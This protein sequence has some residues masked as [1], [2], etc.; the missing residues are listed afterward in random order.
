M[1]KALYVGCCPE[2]MSLRERFEL[3]ARAGFQGIELD[4]GENE[5]LK[6]DISPKE[7]RQVRAWADELGLG[8]T[9]LFCMDLWGRPITHNDPEIRKMTIERLKKTI[10]IASDM[11]VDTCL[12]VAGQVDEEHG[13]RAVWDR[14]IQV[15]RD[16]LLPC[17]ER[18][19]VTLAVETVWNRFLLSPIEFKHY[20]N[21]VNHPRLTCYF[22]AANVAPWSYPWDWIKELGS[23]IT[24][25]HVSGVRLYMTEFLDKNIVNTPG[26]NPLSWVNLLESDFDWRRVIRPLREVGYD[27]WVTIDRSAYGKFYG[28]RPVF[29]MSEELSIVLSV[30]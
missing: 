3:L 16:D 10:A 11:G 27:G 8:I 13:Y 4:I 17:C 30:D 7:V 22:D 12:L 21:T 2:T 5:L 15:L 25:I 24:R 19:Q 14:S 28:E 9:D 23:L 18:H 20:L 1:K 6:F 26:F 29:R